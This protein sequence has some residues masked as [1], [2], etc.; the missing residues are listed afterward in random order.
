MRRLA[1][2]LI[3]VLPLINLSLK[4][5]F[6]AD[7]LEAG[8]FL[9][10]STIGGDLVKSDFG[11]VNQINAAYGLM[12]RRYFHPNIAAR[13]A[14]VRTTLR[15]QAQQFDQFGSQTVRSETP[16]IEVT[17]DCQYDALGHQRNWLAKKGGVSPYGFLGFGFAFTDPELSYPNESEELAADKNADVSKT[18]FILPFGAGVRWNFSTRGSICLELTARP[19]FSDYLDGISLAGNPNKNDWYGFGGIQFWYRLSGK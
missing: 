9:G 19:T 18:R 16:L 17:V 7:L 8:V 3:F 4:G 1:L 10:G 13:V 11:S 6:S 14:A 15:S 12:V 2:T 5:Q